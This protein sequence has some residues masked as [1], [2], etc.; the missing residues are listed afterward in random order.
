MDEGSF[1][2]PTENAAPA[3]VCIGR[4]K[5]HTHH[6]TGNYTKIPVTYFTNMKTTDASDAVK[7]LFILDFQSPV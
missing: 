7:A 5:D 1:V 6:T 3:H 4:E 2:K